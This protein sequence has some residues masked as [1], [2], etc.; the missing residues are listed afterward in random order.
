M[1]YSMLKSI[2]GVGIY[3]VVESVDGRSKFKFPTAFKI[4]GGKKN[5]K[6]L[7]KTNF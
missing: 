7:G 6:L 5:G 3:I 1:C 2:R 4:I